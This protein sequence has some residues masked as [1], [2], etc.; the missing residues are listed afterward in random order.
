MRERK[1]A[2]GKKCRLEIKD[3]DAIDT[4]GMID[5][6]KPL[7]FEDIGL[8]LPDVPPTQVISIRLPS[9]LINELRAISS[10]ADIPYQALIKLLLSGSVSKFK[11]GFIA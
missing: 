8:R 1:K 6:S 9:A 4:S 3:Y 5:T 10:Q 7:K 11:K 2:D